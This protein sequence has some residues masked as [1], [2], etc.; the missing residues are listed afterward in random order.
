M[1]HWE[2]TLFFT[3]CKHYLAW[4]RTWH[5]LLL[6]VSITKTDM[7]VYQFFEIGLHVGRLRQYVESV[8]CF[9]FHLKWILIEILSTSL[10]ITLDSLNIQNRFEYRRLIKCSIRNNV[11]ENLKGFAM[12]T[13]N[14]FQEANY[15]DKI[16]TN[17]TLNTWNALIYILRTLREVFFE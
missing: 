16:W 11:C 2:K 5:W 7:K 9:S 15:A 3:L 6:A 8:E 13:W 12:V 1:W 4:G 10:H 14:T 17:E